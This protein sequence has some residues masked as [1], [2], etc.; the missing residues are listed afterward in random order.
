VDPVAPK[1]DD[2]E[3]RDGE[4]VRSVG[5]SDRVSAVSAEPPTVRT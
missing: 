4:H 5:P 3:H 2:V 1:L